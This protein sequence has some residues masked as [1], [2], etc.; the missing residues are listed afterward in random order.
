MVVYEP[1]LDVERCFNLTILIKQAILILKS[2]LNSFT[3][4][5]TGRLCI[6][7]EASRY[8]IL[9]TDLEVI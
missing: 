2:H 5:K 7:N 8:M 6:N 1:G 4:K 3:T 9:V